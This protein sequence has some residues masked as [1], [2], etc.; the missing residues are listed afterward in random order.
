MSYTHTCC[1]WCCG[2]QLVRIS[3]FR[4]HRHD[5]SL[6]WHLLWE[7]WRFW[8]IRWLEN[9]GGIFPATAGGWGTNER[10]KAQ[11]K[12]RRVSEKQKC[13]VITVCVEHSSSMR[14]K[15]AE[16]QEWFAPERT[17]YLLS[18]F[19]VTQLLLPESE[20]MYMQTQNGSCKINKEPRSLCEKK[21]NIFHQKTELEKLGFV[22]WRERLV[23]WELTSY[24]L[25]SSPW[26]KFLSNDKSLSLKLSSDTFQLRDNLVREAESLFICV[27][28]FKHRHTVKKAYMMQT[29]HWDYI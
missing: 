22:S 12:L 20:C 5:F 16:Q 28:S 9:E 6:H 26:W 23:R 11:I 8:D 15:E 29:M 13:W 24:S 7:F 18:A 21:H 3:K 1:S 17:A 4:E 19:K 27:G 14:D 2:L 25:S 10:Q